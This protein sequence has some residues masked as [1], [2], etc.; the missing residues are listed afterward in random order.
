[1]KHIET[2]DYEGMKSVCCGAE[3][4]DGTF[5]ICGNCQEHTGFEPDE[6]ESPYPTPDEI[7]EMKKEYLKEKDIQEAKAYIE[8]RRETLLEQADYLK[9]QQREN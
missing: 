3:V 9:K 4:I 8:D 7:A 1:M 5:D 2:P 6:D